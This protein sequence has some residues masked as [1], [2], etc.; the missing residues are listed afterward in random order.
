L[1]E[2]GALL[3]AAAPPGERARWFAP[4]GEGARVLLAS[5]VERE[6]EPTLDEWLELTTLHEEGHLTD[7]TRFLP[8]W[9]NWPGV[10]GLLLRH[11][12]T[13]RAVA[14]A[15]EYRAQLV[16]LCCAADPR[17]VLSE[18]LAAADEEGG[19]LAHGEAYRALLED[20]LAVLE[21]HAEEF[22]ALDPRHYWIHQLHFL[23]AEDVRRL[24]HLQAERHGMI[25][26][27]FSAGART[28]AAGH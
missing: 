20:L 8:L 28:P 2:R 21:R 13:P 15:L 24:A 3:P 27:D 19:V 23:A 16:A 18:C 5:L 25:R 17:W 9:A 12:F 11:G 22:P 10:L 7:R 6:A 4:L 26:Q 1:A 14:R